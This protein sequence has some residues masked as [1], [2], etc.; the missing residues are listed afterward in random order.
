MNFFSNFWKF[1]KQQKEEQEEI[2]LII[3]LILMCAVFL[4]LARPEARTLYS[5]FACSRKYKLFASSPC[6]QIHTQINSQRWRL[7]GRVLSSKFFICSKACWSIIM[8]A[9]YFI[10][11][12]F[13]VRR[14]KLVK[15]SNSFFFEFSLS[16]AQK[17]HSRAGHVVDFL[18]TYTS[19]PPPGILCQLI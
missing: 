4:L 19:P 16:A 3:E 12:C 1:K 7:L 18:V 10:V 8:Q 5:P 13:T 11:Q 2:F 14:S 6:V 15:G 9:S 17:L